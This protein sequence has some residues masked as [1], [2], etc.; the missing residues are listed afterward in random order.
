MQIGMAVNVPQTEEERQKLGRLITALDTA[1]FHATGM[2]LT[3]Q[4]Q[5]GPEFLMALSQQLMNTWRRSK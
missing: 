2:G 1:A 5:S 3:I 4:G